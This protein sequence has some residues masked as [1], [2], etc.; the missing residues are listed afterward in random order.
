MRTRL[1]LLVLAASLLPASLVL[2]VAW[3]QLGR[4]I[5]VWT[6]PSV[7]TALQVALNVNRRALDRLSGV[8]ATEG[9]I[10]AESSLFPPAPADTV[11]L[12]E[13]LASGCRE[14]GID[15]AQFYAADGERFLLLS[16]QTTAGS[17]GPDESRQLHPP[18]VSGIGPQ[19]P[20]PLRFRDPEADLLAVPTYLWER[21]P[22]T[23]TTRLR[24]ALVLG[25]R[26]GP[27]YYDELQEVSQSLSLYRRL[28]EMG[29]L[30]QTGYGL[31]AGLV[32]AASLGLSL[33]IARRVAASVSRPIDALIVDMD[34]IGR[35]AADPLD[36]PEPRGIERG[37]SIPELSRLASAFDTMRRTLHDYEDRLRESERVRGAQETARFVAHEIRNTLTP[38]RA[39]L[40]VLERQLREAAGD[41]RPRA[42]RALELIQRETDRMTALA[43]A[44][45][46][47]ARF[48]ERHPERLDLARLAAEVARAEVPGRIELA[49][50]VPGTLPEVHVD[51]EEMERIVRNLVKN[52]VEAIP[53]SG[54]IEVRCHAGER[55]DIVLEIA[56][57]G[58]GM[59]E[60]TLRQALHPGFTTKETGS[61]LGLALVRRSISHYGGSVQLE[62]RRGEGTCCRI[63]L[64]AAPAATAGRDE[65]GI[66]DS[67]RG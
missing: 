38:I 39:S 33:F 59:D 32:L 17:G 13:L 12:N 2:L 8:L 60:E 50:D 48:P 65:N 63:R 9:R 21:T 15:L 43:G 57:S 51:R 45:S 46:E 61:G 35:H 18:A 55:G 22:G 49:I 36:P 37:T 56:D 40:A 64:P 6:I 24:G 14:F 5:G 34:R 53:E 41:Q 31:L 11:G 29:R 23:D 25:I 67:D 10:L 52:G 66:Q 28:Q 3:V 27:N 1:F 44:F 26:L 30:L 4:Q 20:L 7:E 16:S 54:R 42:T 19:R 62:S 58:V 47:Y